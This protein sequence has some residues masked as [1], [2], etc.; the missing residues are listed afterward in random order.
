MNLNE[1]L[2]LSKTESSIKKIDLY[3]SKSIMYSNEFMAALKYKAEIISF[4]G[5]P[6]KAIKMLADY[7]PYFDKMDN[8]SIII[9]LDGIINITLSLSLF[10]QADNFIELKKKYL[11]ISKSSLYLKD[12][13]NFYLLKNDKENAKAIL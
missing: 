1:V 12:R 9:T 2:N 8:E 5:E 11:P 10:E 6:N 4:L 7:M 13:I 3:L